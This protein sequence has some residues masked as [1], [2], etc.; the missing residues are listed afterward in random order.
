MENQQL[1]LEKELEPIFTKSLPSFPENIKDII[2]QIAP[3]L[4]LLGA[5]VGAISF[6][7]LVTA[8]SFLSIINLGSDAYGG[9]TWAMVLG[10]LLL[11]AI[12]YFCAVSYK[13]LLNQE[14]KGWKNIYLLSLL[15][16]GLNLLSG[17]FI[18]AILGAFVGFWVLFQVKGRFVK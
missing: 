12:T 15:S 8:G 6:L 5:I 18:S 10:M 14:Y 3:W 17:S 9:S 1:L 4:A 2:V 13:P 16:F 7:L 11:A